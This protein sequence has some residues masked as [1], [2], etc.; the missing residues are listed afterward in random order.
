[1][2]FVC[3]NKSMEIKF[4][5]VLEIIFFVWDNFEKRMEKNNNNKF[6]VLE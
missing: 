1:M 2:I 3:V 6:L 5:I 4:K